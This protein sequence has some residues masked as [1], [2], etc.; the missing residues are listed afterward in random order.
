MTELTVENT[1]QILKD[2]GMTVES[3]TEY[4]SRARV[5]SLIS[6]NESAIAKERAD[7]Q[8]A[9]TASN[10]RIA[11]LQAEIAALTASLMPQ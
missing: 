8:E 1:M 7:Q 2:C 5:L 11:A 3:L 6:I 10:A 9:L 4:L